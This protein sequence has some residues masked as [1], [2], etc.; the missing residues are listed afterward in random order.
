MFLLWGIA[1][2][3][4]SVLLF[5]IQ[6]PLRKMNKWWISL[7]SFV[8]KFILATLFAFL[9]LGVP[10]AI[11]YWTMVLFGL[12]YIVLMGDAISDIAVI[13]IAF[14][15]KE[16][17][18]VLSLILGLVFTMGFFSYA[19]FN[20]QITAPEYHTFVTDKTN[21]EYKVVFLSDLHYGTAQTEK[22]LLNTLDKIRA[23]KPDFILLGG[24]ITDDFTTL[25]ELQFLYKQIGN[26]D[27]PAY[28][29][30]GNHDRQ[31][32]F[33]VYGD[34]KYTDEQ[35]VDAITSNEIT[36]L[37]DEYALFGDDIVLLG[38]EDISHDTRLP[39]EKLPSFPKDRLVIC[40]DHS[41]YQYDDIASDGADLQ[42]SGHT[43]A[44]QLFPL[45]FF[46]EMA[47]DYVYGEFN[48]ENT[49]LITSSGVS[50]WAFPFRT[51]AHS[52]YDVIEIK[53]P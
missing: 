25:D 21:R 41:P 46:Y 18:P 14:A 27:I 35:L 29:I 32:Y 42:I 26:L 53:N 15:S 37:C 11:P 48:I 20:M 19:Y 2:F 9:C 3:V 50:G 33:E 51:E 30:Y 39:V 28:F 44:G 4:V 10:F 45:H 47:K 34:R 16:Y 17:K 38:R 13:I 52:Y 6:M 24:D 5:I 36:I 8:I 1:A 40:V 22:S 12:L 23:E 31:D 7:I 49:E 43:H